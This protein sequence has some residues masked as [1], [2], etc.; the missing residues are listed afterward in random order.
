MP[1]QKEY[2]SIER[3]EEIAKKHNI[4]LRKDH[5]VIKSSK[6]VVILDVESNATAYI[7]DEEIAKL[8]GKSKS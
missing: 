8:T 4:E 2:V 5:V 6:G 3:I 7:T 1:K